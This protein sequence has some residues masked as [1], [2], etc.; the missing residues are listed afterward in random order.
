MHRRVNQIIDNSQFLVMSMSRPFLNSITLKKY[1]Y[2]RR[3][4]YMVVVVVVISD[5]SLGASLVLMLSLSVKYSF[6]FSYKYLNQFSLNGLSDNRERERDQEL[7]LF[8]LRK[9]L[10]A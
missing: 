1:Y 9:Y 2:K 6:C 8:N 4:N 5:V 10:N 3:V 7:G